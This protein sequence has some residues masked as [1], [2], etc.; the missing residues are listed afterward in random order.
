MSDSILEK[1][2]S[3]LSEAAKT[4]V[5]KDAVDNAVSR[6]IEGG[7]SLLHNLEE[8]KEHEKWNHLRLT[9]FGFSFEDVYQQNLLLLHL[10]LLASPLILL[11][12]LQNALDR[13]LSCCIPDLFETW[14]NQY[15][16]DCAL[17]DSVTS[18]YYLAFF[19]PSIPKHENLWTTTTNRALSSS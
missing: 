6:G 2:T 13:K 19:I 1:A 3:A 7:K 5:F 8:K 9:T 14:P 10:P 12:F 16:N 15:Y 4:D 17:F 11:A 18:E